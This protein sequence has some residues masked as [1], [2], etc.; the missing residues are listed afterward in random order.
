MRSNVVNL[1]APSIEPMDD[2]VNS[3]VS[4]LFD[5][6]R[7]QGVNTDGMQFRYSAAS[8]KTIMQ[9]LLADKE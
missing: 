1:F 8:I 4:S 7:S 9:A 6:A 2:G 5:W 3:V